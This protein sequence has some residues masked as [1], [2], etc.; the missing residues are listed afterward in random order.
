MR[1]SRASGE[2]GRTWRQPWHPRT[3]P[4]LPCGGTRHPADERAPVGL[5]GHDRGPRVAAAQDPLARGWTEEEDRTRRQGLRG[6]RLSL[7][8]P[9]LFLTQLRA[10]LRAAAMVG[11]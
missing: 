6:V 4:A 8:R 10:L 7:T 1:T 3:A 9:E 5:P 2:R 11:R